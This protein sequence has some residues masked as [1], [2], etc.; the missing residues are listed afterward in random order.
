MKNNKFKISAIILVML[1]LAITTIVSCDKKLDK[2]NPN[3]LTVESYFKTSEELEKGVNAAYGVMRSPNLVG[4]EWFFLHDTRCDENNTGGGQLEAERQ[5][6]LSGNTDPTNPI[7]AKTWSSLYVMIHRCNTVI[8]NGGNGQDNPSKTA[9]VVGEAKFLRAWAYNEL[10]THW[11]PVPLILAPATSPSDYKP[12]ASEADIYATMVSDLTA[13]VAALPGKSG[14]PASENGRATKAAAN[15][16]LGRVLMQ[17]GDYPGA[18]QALLAIPTSG[19]D[20]YGLMNRYL[21][22]FEEEAEFNNESIFE[23][24]Y[25]DKGDNNYNWNNQQTGDGKGEPVSTVRNQEYNAV[26]WRNL[27]PSNK[28]LA[29]FEHTVAGSPK[30]DPRLGFSV[31]KTGDPI[32]NGTETLTDA[33]QNGNSSVLNG[34][35]IKISWRKFMIT[36][37]ENSGFHPGGNNQRLFR[38]AE[39][40]L[41]LAE[42]EAEANNFSA[43]NGAVYYLNL[44]RARSSVAMPAYPTT[45]YP[46]TTKTDVIKALIHEKMAEMGSEEVRN[47]DIMRWRKKAYFGADPLAYFRANRDELVPLPQQEI[48]NNPKLGAGGIPKQNPGY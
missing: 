25:V 37:K 39:V 16:L 38:Y 27:I 36:Y 28:Y 8:A 5:Q 14:Y 42:C 4:R 10:V 1:S 35:T 43:T 13:A 2:L 23:V 19:A 44:I 17:K 41:N 9:R 47:V 20:G 45:Q 30:T 31:Y 24:V 46:V 32:N 11:G 40:L 22:N 12:R 18:K 21:D 48:D 33:M 3:S 26:A 15:F 7:I 34:A 29:N 6:M